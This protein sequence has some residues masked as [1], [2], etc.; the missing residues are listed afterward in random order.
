MGR[1][2]TPEGEARRRRQ[3]W[4]YARKRSGLSTGE[5]AE[6]VG[7]SVWSVKAY[8]KSAGNVPTWDA[9]HLLKDHNLEVA[10]DIVEEKFGLGALVRFRQEEAR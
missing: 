7:K 5:I 9:I 1:K 6:L 3:A 8:G 2:A 10:V 4:S